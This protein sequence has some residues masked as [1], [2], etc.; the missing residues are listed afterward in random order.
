M[1][2]PRVE[3]RALLRET[4]LAH[5][6]RGALSDLQGVVLACPHRGLAEL[7]L[8]LVGEGRARLLVDVLGAVAPSRVPPG[9]RLWRL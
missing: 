8:E 3:P 6:E 2:D 1:H 9:V 5:V 7:A 4:G